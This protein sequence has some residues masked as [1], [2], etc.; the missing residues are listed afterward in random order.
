MLRRENI[1]RVRVKLDIEGI[2]R[3]AGMDLAGVAPAQLP[4]EDVRFWRDWVSAGLH[5]EMKYLQNNMRADIRQWYPD[6]KC[7]IMTALRY[8]RLP[9]A[10]ELLI[11]TENSQDKCVGKIA[12]YVRK[13][14]YH[15]ALKGRLAVM[16]S[17]IKKSE[18][19]A[20]GK[21]FVDTS[22]V[23]ERS[24]AKCA[25]LGWIGKNTMLINKDIGSYFYLGGI[26]LNTDLDI[27]GSG[28][29]GVTTGCGT[30]SKCVDACPAKCLA[31]YE[32]DARQ[33]V[34]YLTI[35][36]KEDIPDACARGNAGSWIFGCDICQD[37]CPFN[38]KNSMPSQHLELTGVFEWDR[39]K[40]RSVFKD[41]ALS[42]ASWEKF[43]ANA[44]IAL[45]NSK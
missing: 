7:V 3:Q 23:L 42:R 18:P 29:R 41:T 34:S 6:A 31:S 20:D 21:I 4:Q 8:D 16:L 14:D 37:V 44:R 5:G 10:E 27:K 24:Y 36:K 43:Q 2:A 11:N 32:V 26:A 19:S 39:A 45:E 33:C 1:S 30:C 9:P 40:Y 25:G 17:A 38:K 28:T 15:K 22:P 12:R 13:T 35:E